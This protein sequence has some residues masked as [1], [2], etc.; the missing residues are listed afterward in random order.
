MCNK[1]ALEQKMKFLDLSQSLWRTLR[2][3][4][5][6]LARLH[7]SMGGL[8]LASNAKQGPSAE[9]EKVVNFTC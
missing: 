6:A 7:D 5:S 9:V 1:V 4:C 2:W 3:R 8:P